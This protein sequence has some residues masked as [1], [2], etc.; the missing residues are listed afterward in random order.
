[1][2][3]LPA[4]SPIDLIY[5]DAIHELNS[6]ALSIG[7]LKLGQLVPLSN[8]SLDSNIGWSQPAQWK[9]PTAFGREE[10][11]Q[12]GAA[13]FRPSG[14]VI[15]LGCNEVPKAGGGTYWT[16]DPVDKLDSVEGLDPNDQRKTELLADVIDR[17]KKSK[18]L[19]GQKSEVI[20][21]AFVSLDGVM[22]APG[23]PKEDPTRGFKLGWLVST[24]APEHPRT[25]HHAAALPILP[26][27]LCN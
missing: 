21:R 16:G 5:L 15:T 19:S 3:H 25:N 14:E 24:T 18:H 2:V 26:Q 20:T 6:A 22:Q 17:L 11:L 7:S 8:L 9:Y 13:I 4:K 12:V 10:R 1:M 23:G 27:S